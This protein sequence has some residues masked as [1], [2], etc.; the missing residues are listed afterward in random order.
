MHPDHDMNPY[1]Q[2][3]KADFVNL[4][5]VTHTYTIARNP[6]YSLSNTPINKNAHQCKK[7]NHI[8]SILR[9]RGEMKQL[10]SSLVDSSILKT[11]KEPRSKS[12][13]VR[14]DI[15]LEQAVAAL[16]ETPLFKH[17]IL[18]TMRTSALAQI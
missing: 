14:L 3:P 16:E 15:P 12:V 1:T 11:S 10:C 7:A 18:D 17:A 5:T 9:R 13:R 8:L 6:N 4:H 2:Y